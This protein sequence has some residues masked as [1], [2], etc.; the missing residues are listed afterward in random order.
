MTKSLPL[1]KRFSC[2]S[3]N[4][5]A[6]LSHSTALIPPSCS[7]AMC[8][9]TFHRWMAS[10]FFLAFETSISA[11]LLNR[12]ISFSHNDFLLSPVNWHNVSTAEFSTNFP[13]VQEMNFLLQFQM[14]EHWSDGDSSALR[15]R[16]GNRISDVVSILPLCWQLKKRSIEQKLILTCSIIVWCFDSFFI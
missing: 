12:M 16:I 5:G 1:A 8:Y 14:I 7:H 2:M 9:Q 13:S 11:T 4:T 10:A 3:L 15:D 6:V